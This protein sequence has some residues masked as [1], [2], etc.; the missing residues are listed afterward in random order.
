MGVSILLLM[1]GDEKN[2][3]L[4][5]KAKAQRTSF[6]DVC[7]LNVGTIVLLQTSISDLFILGYLLDTV[8]YLSFS[9]SQSEFKIR[10]ERVLA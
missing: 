3:G 6:M 7:A 1:S 4:F 8:Q 10:F 9:S 2:L 5:S